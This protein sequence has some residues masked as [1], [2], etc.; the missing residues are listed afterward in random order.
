MKTLFYYIVFFSSPFLYALLHK[1][2]KLDLFLLRILGNELL[3]I[4]M[5]CYLVCLLSVKVGSVKLKDPALHDPATKSK[6]KPVTSPL[7]RIH[8][9]AIVKRV[10]LTSIFMSIK[11]CF[12]L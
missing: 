4:Y 1:R 9:L 6:Q 2:N 8:S 7:K 3:G 11:K 5:P 12:F 10:S